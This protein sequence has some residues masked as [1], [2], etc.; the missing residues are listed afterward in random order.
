MARTPIWN[1]ICA[2]LAPTSAADVQDEL[3][4]HIETKLAS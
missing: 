3:R 1:A 4:F 2:S